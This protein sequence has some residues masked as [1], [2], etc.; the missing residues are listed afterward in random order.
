MLSFNRFGFAAER[1]RLLDQ[2]AA[3]GANIHE[4]AARIAKSRLVSEPATPEVRS[5]TI[6]PDPHTQ[7]V[8]CGIVVISPV[9]G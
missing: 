6:H 5:S 4:T 3:A 7:H 1:D 2:Y 8:V 9:R